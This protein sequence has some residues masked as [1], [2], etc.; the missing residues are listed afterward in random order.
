[1]TRERLASSEE[2]A[3]EYRHSIYK[4]TTELRIQT[5]VEYPRKEPRLGLRSRPH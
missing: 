5:E 2:N 3:K 1:M 4:A